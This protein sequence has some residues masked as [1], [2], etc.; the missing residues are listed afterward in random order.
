MTE[1]LLSASKVAEILGLSTRTVQDMLRANK[2]PSC[3]VLNRRRMVPEGAL[4]TWIKQNT[5]LPDPES[6]DG[7]QRPGMSSGAKEA[8]SVAGLQAR[9]I[10]T[11][12]SDG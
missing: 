2:L 9:L 10:D 3:K 6:T 7:N 11:K 1:R 8:A 12:P 4:N 5:A